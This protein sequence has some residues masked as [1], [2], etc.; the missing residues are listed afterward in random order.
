[1]DTERE[2]RPRR[3]ALEKTVCMEKEGRA[4][5]G[6]QRWRRKPS[7]ATPRPARTRLAAPAPRTPVF[8]FVL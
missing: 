2:S 4:D 8:P 1:M 7:P 5:R 3:P 6:G